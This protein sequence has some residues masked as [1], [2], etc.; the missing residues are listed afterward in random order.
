MKSLETK[1]EDAFL[2]WQTNLNASIRNDVA[3]DSLDRDLMTVFVWRG[4]SVS[5]D[6][7]KELEDQLKTIEARLLVSALHREG[8]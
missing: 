6:H 1:I 3:Y 5:R 8:L 2:D 7:L 4:A